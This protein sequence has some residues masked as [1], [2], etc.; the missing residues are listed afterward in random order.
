M[1]R[2]GAGST[3]GRVGVCG[4]ETSVSGGITATCIVA[5]GTCSLV[6]RPFA[7]EFVACN[8]T[9]GKGLVKCIV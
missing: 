4:Q 2:W 7:P 1:R 6:P 9:T 8:T 3:D 5:E